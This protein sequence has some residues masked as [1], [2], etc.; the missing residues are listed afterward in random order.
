MQDDRIDRDFDKYMH[1]FKMRACPF[2]QVRRPT[3]KL[4]EADNGISPRRGGMEEAA[5]A[6]AGAAGVGARPVEAAGEAEVDMVAVGTTPRPTSPARAST[7]W[8]SAAIEEEESNV[9]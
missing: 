7:T 3:C 1:H 9:N 5:G 8:P 4:S 6:T 2:Y